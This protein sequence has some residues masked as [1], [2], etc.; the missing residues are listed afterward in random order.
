MTRVFAARAWIVVTSAVFVPGTLAGPSF[1]RTWIVDQKHSK[2]DDTYWNLDCP[3]VE[4][5]EVDFFGT[6]M[7]EAGRLPG[8]FQNAQKGKNRLVLWP[9]RAL[10]EQ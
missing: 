5:V 8:P 4:G 3:S 10:C 9:V 6:P 2:A 1:G 7:P